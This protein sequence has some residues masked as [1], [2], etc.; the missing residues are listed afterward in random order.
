[1][2]IKDFNERD[3][4]KQPLLITMLNNGVTNSGA[5]Y[6]TV[7]LSDNTGTIEGKVWEVDPALVQTLKLGHIVEISA[8]VIKYKNSFQLKIGSIELKN[9]KIYNLSEFLKTSDIS[10][11]E[12]K[13]RIYK[14]ID[15]IKNPIL[16]KIVTKLFEEYEDGFFVYPAAAKNHHE[17]IGGLATHTLEMIEIGRG[18]LQL[19]PW[20]NKDLLFSGI[21]VHDLC[22]IDE[23]QS[24]VV[25]EYS[26]EG[27]LLGHISMAQARVMEVAK[28][29]G[30]EHEES[31]ILLRH[32]ILSHHGQYEFGSPVLPLIAEA[33]LLNLIDNVS[34]RLTMFNKAYQSVSEGEFTS[35]IFPLE[36]RSLYKPKGE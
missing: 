27:K 11:S 33:E 24:P 30:F 6:L 23:Y 17:Y 36:Q 25:V 35:R 2:K 15:E 21:L 3:H 31:V 1:M 28:S 8:D 34:A 4:I 12:L 9:Q 32:M 13:D 22:K 14:A 19:Y 16:Y 26:L 7:G 5:P 29:F 18:I 10:K 20:L